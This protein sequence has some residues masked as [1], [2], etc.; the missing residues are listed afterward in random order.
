[1]GF[2]RIVIIFYFP[3][4]Y[5]YFPYFLL[6]MMCILITISS[7]PAIVRPHAVAVLSASNARMVATY[8]TS[9][10]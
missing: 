5:I 8:F 10:A 4:P 3:Y 2:C 6:F 1:V 7:P 9:I